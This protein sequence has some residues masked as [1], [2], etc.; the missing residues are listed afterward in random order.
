MGKKR[1]L[2]T[3]SSNKN[4]GA[5]KRQRNQNISR[6][7]RRSL[8]HD[9]LNAE[10]ETIDLTASTASSST[11]AMASTATTAAT[12]IFENNDIAPSTPPRQHDMQLALPNIREQRHF[13]RQQQ[14]Q[15]EELMPIGASL[16]N[17]NENNLGSRYMPPIR[18]RNRNPNDFKTWVLTFNDHSPLATNLSPNSSE[19]STP[20]SSPKRR[21]NRS[22]RN[23][24]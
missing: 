13:R 8:L 23:N 1:L 19:D 14:E 17:N 2:F 4:D 11:A 7:V 15:Q 3:D 10:D 6:H 20:E 24:L 5:N 12:T 16:F 21:D 18:P 9:F 22:P